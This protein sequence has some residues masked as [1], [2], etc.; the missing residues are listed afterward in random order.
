[1]RVIANCLENP[2][3]PD[4]IVVEQLLRLAP[5]QTLPGMVMPLI[6]GTGYHSKT[7]CFVHFDGP[8]GEEVPFLPFVV[9][10]TPKIDGVARRRSSAVILLN[11]DPAKR[12]GRP[13]Y[14]LKR[15]MRHGFMAPLR[16]GADFLGLNSSYLNAD[17]LV[18][19]LSVP[20]S[21]SIT[22]EWLTQGGGL[23]PEKLTVPQGA[24]S[25]GYKGLAGR[26]KN[27]QKGQGLRGLFTRVTTR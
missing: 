14:F 26:L 6:D 24:L 3:W 25:R 23:V 1:M 12:M 15:E 20:P 2:S 11:G 10:D 27:A 7:E 21:I 5:D 4:E 8:D 19:Q 22:S 9:H 18:I 16:D 17:E 13:I